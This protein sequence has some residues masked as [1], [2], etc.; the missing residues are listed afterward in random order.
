MNAMRKKIETIMTGAGKAPVM[1][2]ASVLY[3]ISVG[4]AGIQKLRGAWYR[5]QLSSS[6]RLPCKVIS[7]GNITVGGTGK[8]PMTMHVANRMKRFGYRVAVLSRGYKGGAEQTETVVSD[9]QQILMGPEIAGDEPYMHACRLPGIAVIV[10]KNRF[11]AGML[12]MNTFQ[13]DVII[14]DDGFQH[15]RLAR[16]IDLVLLDYRQP[17]GN[18]H[19]LPRGT[20]REPLKSLTRADA[21]VLTR[22]TVGPQIGSLSAADRLKS[23][24][25]HCPVFLSSHNLYFYSVPRRAKA[26]LADLTRQAISNP[27]DFLARRRVLA[28]SGLARNDD[29]KQS[30]DNFDC[31]VTRFL[32]FPDHHPYS[33]SDFGSITR[34]AK[35]TSA[36]FLI[37]TEKDYARIAQRT[38]WPLEL[39]VIGVKI[40]FGKDEERFDEFLKERLSR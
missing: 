11:A 15:V 40:S 20:L 1:S 30:V 27:P 8:T 28:F 29:F 10:G 31:D 36:E 2:L 35:Q 13:P 32:Q 5:R 33:D 12:A 24:A 26:S 22:S 25:P 19:L 16:D 18:L 21:F 34:A 7:V 9:G 39:I 17:F 14:L 23:I 37:T 4:Y 3:M 38:D 6:K